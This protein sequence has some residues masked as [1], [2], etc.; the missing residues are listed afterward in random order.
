M[1]GELTP[2]IPREF[3][4]EQNYPNPFNPS[5]NIVYSIPENGFVALKVFDLLGEE[6][7][8]LVN[9]PMQSGTYSVQ[10]DAKNLSSGTYFY[11]LQTEKFTDTKRMLYLK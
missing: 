6:V 7:A 8:T 9:E 10:F 5:T 11:R 3:K 1:R 4:L 2:E